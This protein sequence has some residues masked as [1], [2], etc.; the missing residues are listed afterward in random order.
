LRHQRHRVEPISDARAERFLHA[1]P[2]AGRHRRSTDEKHAFEAARLEPAR[3]EQP[4]ANGEALVDERRDESVE[5]VARHENV[6]VAPLP[7]DLEP[8]DDDRRLPGAGQLDLGFFCCVTQPA[9]SDR[10]RRVLAF[11]RHARLGELA[12]EPIDERG[13]E[14]A[15]AEKVV[16]V[17]ADHA[18]EALA[19]FEQR[20]VE[21]SAAEVVDEP[22]ARRF[23]RRP[24]GGDGRRDRLLD[25][26][27]AL[28]SGKTCRLRCG[29][30]LGELEQGRNRHHRLLGRRP[31]LIGD[32]FAQR[33]QDLGGELLRRTFR[34]AGGELELVARAHEAFE[35]GARVGRVRVEKPPRPRADEHVAAGV[36]ADHARRENAALG[37]SDDGHF[38]AVEHGR[39]GVGGTEVDTQVE[40]SA[41]HRSAD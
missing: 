16:P 8:G 40:G 7:V 5:L 20:D 21:R 30:R 22:R 39:R 34:S 35:F 38:L 13:V 31:E 6:D 33:T 23:A 17:V 3:R 36:D 10:V 4:V 18:Q 14:V 9:Q 2:Q 41:V 11:D 24:T 32:V 29:G 1:R 15:S 19:R 26:L 37:V 28:E 12:E 25:E 27:D